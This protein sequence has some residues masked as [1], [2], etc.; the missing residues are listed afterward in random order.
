MSLLIHLSAVYN[1]SLLVCLCRFLEKLLRMLP[2]PTGVVIALTFIGTMFC[3]FISHCVYQRTNSRKYHTLPVVEQCKIDRYFGTAIATVLSFAFALIAFFYDPDFHQ[4]AL[5]GSSAIGNAALSIT[6]GQFLSDF[7]YEKRVVGTFGSIRNQGHHFAAISGAALGFYFFHRLIIYR[8]I[9]HL[10]LPS[11]IIY[12]LMRKLKCDTRGRLFKCVMYANL[13][14][15][16][17]FRVV[18]IPFHWVWYIYEIVTWRDEWPQ[19]WLLAWITIIAGSVVIDCVNCCW[20]KGFIKI[21]RE[22]NR[23]YENDKSI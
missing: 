22:S 3:H 15:F 16:F 2:L 14:I 23:G 17:L 19:I 20:A 21:Y 7:L 12:D 4:L 8:F 6:I 13:F 9:H 11:V 1:S 10:S 5:V 18:V